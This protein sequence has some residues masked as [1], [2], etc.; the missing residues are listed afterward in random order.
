[1][2]IQFKVFNVINLYIINE[3]KKI[4]FYKIIYYYL[5]DKLRDLGI[6]YFIKLWG[7]YYESFLVVVNKCLDQ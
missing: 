2:S 7:I 1:M 4:F 5:E 3:N 6:R